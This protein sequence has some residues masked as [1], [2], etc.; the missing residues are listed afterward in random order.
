MTIGELINNIAQKAGIAADDAKLKSLLS[1]PELASV[2][3]DAELATAVDS[4]LISMEQAKNNHPEIK[5]IY[6]AAAFDGAARHMGNII[7]TDTF[8]QADLDEI[9]KEPLFTKKIELVI[10]KLKA[11]KANAKGADKDEVNRKLAE[12]HEAAKLAKDEVVKVKQDYEGKISEIQMRAA[13]KAVFSN[14]KTIYDDLPP[15][16]K[17]AAFEALVTTALQD[18]NAQLKTDEQGNLVLLAKDG[19]N[20]FGANHVQLTPSSFLDQTFAPILKTRGDKPDYKPGTQ[21]IIPG[22]KP[23]E[24]AEATVSQISSH[25]DAVLAQLSKPQATLV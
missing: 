19:S 23:D 17:N 12:A 7:G 1:S 25:N 22:A 6:A 15:A 20:V 8:E 10:S 24:K 11:Q 3:V 4:A 2:Q 18:K 14:Y 13:L 16:A 21:P 5:K 9:N